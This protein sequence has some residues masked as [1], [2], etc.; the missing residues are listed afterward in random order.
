MKYSIKLISG[1]NEITLPSSFSNTKK[2]K[3]SKL[4][5]RFISENQKILN[6]T[7]ENYAT[8][9]HFDGLT[10]S[11]YTLILYNNGQINNLI[12]Y[13]N[14][15]NNN[16]DIIYEYGDVLT[17]INLNVYIDGVL[18]PDITQNNPL[19]IEIECQF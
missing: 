13:I 7:V 6:I 17:S 14:T 8:N 16:W 12:N 9:V 3:I 11:N 2:L 4:L 15:D 5:Y 19:Y 18:N 10:T 1:Q